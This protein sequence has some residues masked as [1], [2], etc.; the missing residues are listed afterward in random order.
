MPPESSRCQT[1]L[2]CAVCAH[3]PEVAGSNPAPATKVR[4]PENDR[5]FL[6]SRQ[7]LLVHGF[8]HEWA[9]RN[10]GGSV[11]QHHAEARADPLAER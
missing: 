2:N 1:G 10:V 4:G 11:T 3:N 9:N 6:T 7:G 8:V 5:A